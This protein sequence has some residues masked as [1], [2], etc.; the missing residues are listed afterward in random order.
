MLKKIRCVYILDK[1][2]NIIK[3]KKKLNIIKYNKNDLQ[4]HW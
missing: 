2:L 1:I 4:Q 3:N